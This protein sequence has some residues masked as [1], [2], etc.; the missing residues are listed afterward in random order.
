MVFK[1]NQG[2]P[3]LIYDA[4]CSRIYRVE[5]KIL[6]YFIKYVS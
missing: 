3:V 1:T 4:D 2:L 5:V 6:K